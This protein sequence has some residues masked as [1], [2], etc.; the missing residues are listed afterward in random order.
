MCANV[1]SSGL[2]SG[3]FLFLEME[4]QLFQGGNLLNSS[5]YE[6]KVKSIN[7]ALRG[8]ALKGGSEGIPATLADT[9]GVKGVR[10]TH[11]IPHA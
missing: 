11:V 8:W 2:G 3:V 4:N 1:L 10:V 9:H 6:L 7:K 5:S